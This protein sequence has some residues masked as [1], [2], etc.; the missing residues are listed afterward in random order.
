MSISSTFPEIWS[1]TCTLLVGWFT[2][3]WHP[4]PAILTSSA[5]SNW[6]QVTMTSWRQFVWRQILENHLNNL[7]VDLYNRNFAKFDV[8][9]H[10]FW[11]VEDIR[12]RSFAKRSLRRG[13]QD[14][15]KH[16]GFCKVSQEEFAVLH[17][18]AP[19]LY[20]YIDLDRF[21]EINKIHK[22]KQDIWLQMSTLGN[23]TLFFQNSVFFV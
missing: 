23:T 19:L 17:T 22:N 10:N 11:T 12:M 21:M 13:G 8:F 9:D 14:D 7:P 16:V 3:F 5:S 15:T 18:H 6:R 20:I 2:C 1:K 4:Y